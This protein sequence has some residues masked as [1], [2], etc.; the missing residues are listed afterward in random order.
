MARKTIWGRIFVGASTIEGTE[1]RGGETSRTAFSSLNTGNRSTMSAVL[2]RA[3]MEVVRG[4]VNVGKSGEEW[5]VECKS[6]RSGR[7]YSHIYNPTMTRLRSFVTTLGVDEDVPLSGPT[8]AHWSLFVPYIVYLIKNE[9][10]FQAAFNEIKE[11]YEKEGIVRKTHEYQMFVLNDFLYYS[12]HNYVNFDEEIERIPSGIVELSEDLSAEFGGDGGFEFG[13]ISKG[14]SANNATV[15]I[16]PKEFTKFHLPWEEELDPTDKAFIPNLD[17]GKYKVHPH[18]LKTAEIIHAE[19]DSEVPVENIHFYGEAGSG[20]STGAKILAQLL[21]LPYRFMVCSKNTEE[22]DFTG[23]FQPEEGKQTFVHAETPFMASFMRGGVI[24]I[25]EP[26][27]AP[28]NVLIHLNSAMDET[29]CVIV[30]K[31]EVVKRHPNCIIVVTSNVG[32]SGTRDMNEAWKDRFQ[33]SCEFERMDEA[34]MVDIIMRGSGNNNS[35]LI[36]KMIHAAN[37]INLKMEEEYLTGGVCGMRQLINWAREAKYSS[38]LEAARVTIL[39][40]ISQE[41]D[42]AEDYYDKILK[43]MF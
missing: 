25:M 10:E 9:A 34:D 19:H 26:N 15:T 37:M 36:S 5:Y 42:V 41:K 35:A 3:I 12:R 20:K 38:P 2:T 11:A 1:I 14:S 30:R 33:R 13:E 6:S 29:R 28:P 8:F 40:G 23:E 18:V 17:L 43:N 4:N 16:A 21:G 27:A 32:Y 24:E 7:L 39:P 31:S 22:G